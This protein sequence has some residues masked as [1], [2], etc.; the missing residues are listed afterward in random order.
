MFEI[1]NCTKEEIEEITYLEKY[2]KYLIKKLKLN[3]AIFNIIFVDNNE[4][5]NINSTYRGIDKETDVISFAL[6]DNSKIENPEI[7]VLGDIYIAI[8]IAYEQAKLYE[9]SSTREICFL[10]T[11]GLLHLLGYDHMNEEEEKIMFKKQKEL[12]ESYD[13]FR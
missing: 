2:I 8:N 6:E 13:I 11:H 9:H 4:I 10:A 12:L 1:I 7:R 3:K 5:K